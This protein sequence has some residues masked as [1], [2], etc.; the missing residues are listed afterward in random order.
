MNSV[1]KIVIKHPGKIF[2]AFLFITILMLIPVSKIE[3][4]SNMDDFMPENEFKVTRDL[5]VQEFNTTEGIVSLIEAGSGN[6]LTRDGL[7]QLKSIEENISTSEVIEPY[8][9]DYKDP[10]LTIADFVEGALYSISNGTLNI[11]N[12][13]EELLNGA[14]GSLLADKDASSLISKGTGE[15]RQYTMIIVIVDYRMHSEDAYDSVE[16]L[17]LAI[18]D[19]VSKGASDDYETYTLGGLNKEIQDNTVKDLSLLLPIC[20][21]VLLI[22]LVIA[23]RS[24]VD[25]AITVVA[26]FSTLLISFGLF[27]IFNLPFNQMTF[28]AP[29]I[30]L[31]LSVDFAIH[32]LMRFKEEQVMERKSKRNMMRTIRFVGISITLSALTTMAAFASNGLSSIPAIASFG[33]FIALGIGVAFI[34]M[35]MFLP[36]MKQLIVNFQDKRLPRKK[37]ERNITDKIGLKSTRARAKNEHGLGYRGLVAVSRPAYRHPVIVLLIVI[38]LTTA[39][40]VLAAQL[41][42]DISPEEIYAKDSKV[43]KTY[44]LIEDQFPATSPNWVSVLV[45]G[46]ITNPIVLLELDRTVSNLIDDKQVVVND[47]VPNALSILTYSKGLL[48]SGT[49]IPGIMDENAD[50]IPD[51]REDVRNLFNYLYMNGIP[52]YLD[53]EDVHGV[54]SQGAEPGTYD[55]TLVKIEVK[56]VDGLKAQELLDDLE[57]DFESLD[58]INGIELSFMGF[59]FESNYTLQK[60]TEGMV[61]STIL[62][63]ILC[64]VMVIVLFWSLRYG[65]LTSIPV[66][67]VT[68]WILGSTYLLGFNLNPVTATTT[69]M[70]VGIGID[71]SI[72]LVERY[73]QERKK[74]RTIGDSLDSSIGN[75]GMALLTAGTTT[76]S[77]FAIISLSKI[78]MFHAFG[79]VAF[80]IVAYTLIASIFVL[81]AFIVIGEKV[82][83][84]NLLRKNDSKAIIEK[85]KKDKTIFGLQ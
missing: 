51:T 5:M 39:G 21:I 52:G 28:F 9:I 18:K 67:L 79:I 14:I 47:G 55:M 48:E 15:K 68:I 29:I 8:L 40:F 31:V 82:H 37:S 49:Q 22:I 66:I 45:K 76:A 24:I 81:P 30:I 56:D 64:A 59:P 32:I 23:L 42:K 62:S 70:T 36:S 58:I 72:H 13:P 25:V 75:T 77:G 83:H 74:G 17:E 54:L 1:G 60:M 3:T 16:T 71:Y 34:V 12:A 85:I 20:V 65:L 43:L 27:S 11:E 63:I 73:R 10:V 61:V 78:G 46:D 6:I 19:A 44:R 26:L 41:E 4:Q 53:P 69:A 57:N 33:T 80:L 38:G 84:W 35:I 7:I 50:G 2:L